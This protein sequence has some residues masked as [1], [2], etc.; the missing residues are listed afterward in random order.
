MG[1]EQVESLVLKTSAPNG[2]FSGSEPPGR[3]F[4]FCSKG[5]NP[6]QD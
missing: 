3:T 4:A 6:D 2:G 1:T 5:D